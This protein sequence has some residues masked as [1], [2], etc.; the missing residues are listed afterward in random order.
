M[1]EKLLCLLGDLKTIPDDDKLL[2]EAGALWL[3]SPPFPTTCASQ[4]SMRQVPRAVAEPL[5]EKQRDK[6]PK[7]ECD[8]ED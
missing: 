8:S 3:N 2:L 1:R 7:R 6:R 4:V 5:E